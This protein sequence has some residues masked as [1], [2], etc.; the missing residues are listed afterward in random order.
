M[1]SR[2]Y[3]PRDA[4]EVA[5]RARA[6]RVMVRDNRSHVQSL[7]ENDFVRQ[8][9]EIWKNI[10]KTTKQKQKSMVLLFLFIMITSITICR[11]LHIGMIN[12]DP[13]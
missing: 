5:Q 7:Q 3:Q 4:L 13:K 10:R 9:W 12:L 6:V 2:R 1:S 8:K 11:S